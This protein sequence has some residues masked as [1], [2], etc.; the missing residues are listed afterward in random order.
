MSR[1]SA[2]PLSEELIVTRTYSTSSL[3]AVGE[4]T[5]MRCRSEPVNVGGAAVVHVV[6]FGA[7]A[8]GPL[9]DA[10]PASS[11]QPSAG[12]TSKW[13]ASIACGSVIVIVFGPGPLDD[14]AVPWCWSIEASDAQPSAAYSSLPIT[15]APPGC[16][17]Q[18]RRSASSSVVVAPAVT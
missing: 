18:L 11:P 13:S 10:E 15:V 8:I 14:H 6:P 5:F 3:P 16:A 4:T 1:Y 12:S 7:V 2:V 17:A 9:L